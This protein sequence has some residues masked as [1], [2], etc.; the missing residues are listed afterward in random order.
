[1]Q[2]MTIFAISVRIVVV[3]H[4]AHPPLRC[5]LFAVHST[6]DGQHIIQRGRA[7]NFY[8]HDLHSSV[9][10]NVPSRVSVATPVAVSTLFAAAERMPLPNSTSGIT[11]AIVLGGMRKI[12]VPPVLSFSVTAPVR[13]PC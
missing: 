3:S 5:H 10:N 8:F 2:K 1:M 13:T 6:A 7:R 9:P 4:G 11:T 12:A